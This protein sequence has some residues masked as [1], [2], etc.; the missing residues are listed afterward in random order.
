MIKFEKLDAPMER[1]CP[2]CKNKMI[3]T[4][5][6][7]FVACTKTNTECKSCSMK[8]RVFRNGDCEVLLLNTYESFYWIGFI[9]ADGHISK[10]NRLQ[11][12]ISERD[13]GHLSK[14][15]ELIKTDIKIGI[16]RNKGYSTN[17]KFCEIKLMDTGNIAK[18]KAKFNIESNKTYNP[19]L[20][21]NYNNFDD[22][23]LFALLIGCIDGDG[24]IGRR[25]N[26]LSYRATLK[27][28]VSWEKFYKTLFDKL[29][30]TY[31]YSI[32]DGKYINITFASTLP[33]LKQKIIDFDIPALTRKWDT[34]DENYQ[35]TYLKKAL[36]YEKFVTLFEKEYPRNLIMQEV[37]IS[38]ETFYDYKKQFLNAQI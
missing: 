20:F 9:L 7:S 24:S 30:L 32:V 37:E 34:V 6:Q 3:Y 2:T 23:F 26:L 21:E 13:F 31:G 25:K 27:V 29:N 5:K 16:L 33:T 19:P 28:H 15:A 1:E 22:N 4:N 14:F 10:N 18:I 35:S 17:S 8:K 38:K 11:I 12:T 36:K